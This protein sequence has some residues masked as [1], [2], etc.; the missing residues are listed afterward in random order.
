[1]FET[2]ELLRKT[3]NA[4]DDFQD[5]DWK[6]ADDYIFSELSFTVEDLMNLYQGKDVML[7]T[8]SAIEGF[9]PAGLTYEE[10]SEIFADMEAEGFGIELRE[11]DTV[12]GKELAI[13]T[14][15]KH[16]RILLNSGDTPKLEPFWGKL[17]KFWLKRVSGEDTFAFWGKAFD[18]A[19]VVIHKVPKTKNREE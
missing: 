9:A 18:S 12:I 13:V 10:L 7:Y 14:T 17:N 8:G 15:E 11:L 3:V 6:D 19:P 1:M 16:P 5:K 4:S 2:L